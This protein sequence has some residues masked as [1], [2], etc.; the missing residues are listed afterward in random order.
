MPP[1]AALLLFLSLV[2]GGMSLSFL[3]MIPTL[4]LSLLVHLFWSVVEALAT[5]LV[6]FQEN[7]ARPVGRFFD[8]CEF[9]VVAAVHRG[10]G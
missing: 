2:F 7:S 3:V 10:S 6:A 5:H 9:L 8:F 4:S 1:P